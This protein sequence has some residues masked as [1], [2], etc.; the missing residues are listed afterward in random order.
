[1][2]DTNIRGSREVSRREMREPH[3]MHRLPAMCVRRQTAKEVVH[4][5]GYLALRPNDAGRSPNLVW[6]TQENGKAV[7]YDVEPAR[8][9]W[10][11][12]KVNVLSLLPLDDEL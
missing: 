5:L 4:N 7:E 11:R 1:M 3:G 9:D 2:C 6:R 8:S 10:Q 12:I